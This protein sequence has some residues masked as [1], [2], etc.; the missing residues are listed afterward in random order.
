MRRPD[1]TP[2][3]ERSDKVSDR[4]HGLSSLLVDVRPNAEARPDFSYGQPRKAAVSMHRD[5]G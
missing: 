3:E 4:E 5:Q 1:G 2:D